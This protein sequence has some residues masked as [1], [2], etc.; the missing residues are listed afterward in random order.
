MTHIN[1]K[2]RNGFYNFMGHQG[3]PGWESEHFKL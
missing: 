3:A 2:K 1:G